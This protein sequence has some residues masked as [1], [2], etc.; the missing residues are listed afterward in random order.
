MKAL[1]IA[2][3]ALTILIL[4][5][6]GV[7]ALAVFA[8]VKNGFSYEHTMR[9]LHAAALPA[10]LCAALILAIRVL[11]RK[12]GNPGRPKTQRATPYPEREMSA[13]PLFWQRALL[14]CAA[15][16]LIALGV[17][18]GGLWDVLVKAIN[19]CTECIGLG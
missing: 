18:N 3:T 11:G 14:L 5:L 19:I 4:L 10:V 16:A 15:A 6:A 13:R 17:L 2:Q 9:F 12:C 1:R 7:C 8:G